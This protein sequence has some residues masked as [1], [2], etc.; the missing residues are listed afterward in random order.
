MK[1]WI[2][3]TDAFPFKFDVDRMKADL[4]KIDEN[5]LLDHYDPTLDRGW[6]AALLVS[7]HGEMSGRESQRPSWDFSEFV[8]TPLVD[9]LP[10]FREI[11]DYFK[12]PQGRVRILKLAPGAG[13]GLHR[14]VN[15]EVGCLAFNQVRLHVPIITNPKVTFHVGGEVITM[16][17]GRF[18]YVN[19]SKWHFVRNDGDEARYHLVLDLKVNDW[20]RQFF[21]ATTWAE[22][23]EYTWARTMWP[24]RWRIEAVYNRIFD[25]AW[26]AYDG[27]AAQRFVRRLK[28]PRTA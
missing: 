8:R 16:R 13:I 21:P 4:K 26:T 3:L 7:K 25:A 1:T 28:A 2:D 11:L 27:T 23:L 6:R 10:Y 20:L 14:D 15:A 19:F 9:Q 18:Y 24:P 17:P 5:K 12:C 22:Q